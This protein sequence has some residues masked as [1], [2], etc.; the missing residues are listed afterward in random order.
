MFAAASTSPLVSGPALTRATRRASRVVAVRAAHPASGPVE[1]SRR[2]G[3]IGVAGSIAFLSAGP[4]RAI[5]VGK[6]QT[7]NPEPRI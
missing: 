4:A 6:P 1:V 5:D 7:L 3:L 2:E